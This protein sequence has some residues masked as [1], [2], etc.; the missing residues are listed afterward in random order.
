MRRLRGPRERSGGASERRVVEF[1]ARVFFEVVGGG[2]QK[3][4]GLFQLSKRFWLSSPLD[5]WSPKS[6]PLLKKK[7][8]NREKKKTERERERGGV[9]VSQPRRPSR[10]SP[11]SDLF[12]PGL[13]LPPVPPLAPLLLLLI[14]RIIPRGIMVQLQGSPLKS[15]MPKKKKKERGNKQSSFV[16]SGRTE[17]KCFRFKE[18][19]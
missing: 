8:S 9:S 1:F 2:K 12:I 5:S 6:A 13:S 15:V 17:T 18:E 3:T 14:A 19:K 10:T 7:L 11:C 4:N 16:L